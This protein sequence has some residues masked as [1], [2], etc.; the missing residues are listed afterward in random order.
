MNVTILEITFLNQS[1]KDELQILSI[2]NVL[3]FDR[4]LSIGGESNEEDLITH[5]H[6]VWYTST[7]EFESQ[8]WINYDF[9]HTG[10][11]IHLQEQKFSLYLSDTLIVSES[12]F[13]YSFC[14]YDPYV[15]YT[16]TNN[17]QLYTSN[18]NCQEHEFEHYDKF[19][20]SYICLYRLHVCPML[21]MVKI[22]L[23]NN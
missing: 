14:E 17:G 5:D 10:R 22:F 9:K 4:S 20:V 13:I 19:T 21:P 7:S 11:Y 16:N 15:M 2:D 12:D 3:T 8:D 23:C 18:F 1:T 6:R